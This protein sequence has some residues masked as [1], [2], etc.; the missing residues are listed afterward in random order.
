MIIS[1]IILSYVHNVSEDLGFNINGI[2][3]DDTVDETYEVMFNYFENV[4][5]GG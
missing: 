4:D 5:A 1:L 3:T 2:K